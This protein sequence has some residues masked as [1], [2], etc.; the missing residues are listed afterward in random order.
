MKTYYRYESTMR[1]VDIGTY[2]KQGMQGFHNYRDGKHI[3]LD[4]NGGSVRSWGCLIY[5]RELTENEVKDYEL[6]LWGTLTH[7]FILE[8]EIS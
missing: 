7:S 2:P 4:K 6:Y 8:E 5:D 3:V 1:P